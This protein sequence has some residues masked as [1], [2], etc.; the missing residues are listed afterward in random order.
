MKTK[1]VEI[2]SVEDFNGI[3]DEDINNTWYMKILNE[4]N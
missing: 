1:K 3:S 2:K 4:L